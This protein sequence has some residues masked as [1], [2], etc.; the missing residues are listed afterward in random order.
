MVQLRDRRKILLKYL[1][2]KVKFHLFD[3]VWF[4][5]DHV[6]NIRLYNEDRTSFYVRDMNIHSLFK[7]KLMFLALKLDNTSFSNQYSIYLLLVGANK[8]L[9]FPQLVAEQGTTFTKTFN[10]PEIWTN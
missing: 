9:K 3:I 8:V 7:S 10:N 2:W 4:C 6:Q 1:N 5:L